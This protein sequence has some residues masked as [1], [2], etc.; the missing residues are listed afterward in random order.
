MV[1]CSAAFA[2]RWRL[3][4]L[5]AAVALWLMP[6]PASPAGPAALPPMTPVVAPL[7]LR[8]MSFNVWYGGDQVSLPAVV[9]AIRRADADLVAIQEPDGHLEAIAAA[10]GYPYVD[11]RRNLIA[12]YPLFDSG[13]GLRTRAGAAPYGITALDEEHLYAWM[14]V[15]PGEVVAVANT[16]LPSDLYGPEAVRDGASLTEVL[17]LEERTRMPSAR[18]LLALG[19]LAATGVPVF[20]TGDFNT[21]SHLDWTPA[22]QTLRGTAVRYPVVW[23]VTAAL[24]QAGLRDSYREAHPDPVAKPGL[25]WTAG[26]PHPY[27]R[28]NETRDRIDF[29]FSAGPTITLSS[30]LVGE[31]GAP[32][33]DLAIRPYPSDHR[34]VVS[35]FSVV[36]VPAPAL[37]AVEPSMVAVGADFVVRAHDPQSAGWHV[38]VVPA[39]ATPDQPL[40]AAREDLTA[41]R[42]MARF[43][44]T[45]LAVG[46][47]DAVLLA[48]DGHELKRS[49]FAVY[50]PTRPPLLQVA[51]ASLQRGQPIHLRWSNGPGHRHD[52]VGLFRAG[53]DAGVSLTIAYLQAHSQGALELATTSAAGPLPA[54]HY[55][56]RLLRDDSPTVLATTDLILVGP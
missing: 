12:R 21:P 28:P 9:E 1:P 31:P 3:T 10:A 32:E 47:Y 18:P 7:E 19:T 49:R 35:S 26:M 5:A 22:M 27:V 40:R 46:A 38:V 15:R 43:T 55:Q 17:A 37:V 23:P 20:L 16:H 53:D 14:M 4:P 51:S 6:L 25:T 54:G 50:A 52:W 30:Q 41:W 36:P 13:N 2:H 48:S 45:G 34:A 56:L 11:R 24:A 29:I 8:V 42:R 44:S 33:V 39:A